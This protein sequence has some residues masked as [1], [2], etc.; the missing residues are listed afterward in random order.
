MKN[1]TSASNFVVKFLMV[2]PIIFILL[3]YMVSPNYFDP[4][5]G[6][7]LGWFIIGIIVIMLISYLYIL[8][9]IMKVEV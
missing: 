1:S 5:F 2:V 9:R 3:I 8:N 7:V 4:L 6:S